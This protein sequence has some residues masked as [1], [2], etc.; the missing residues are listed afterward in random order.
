MINNT[1]VT[2]YYPNGL[3]NYLVL[4]VTT[5]KETAGSF[6]NPTATFNGSMTLEQSA[7][8]GITNPPGMYIFTKEVSVGDTGTI[9]VNSTQTATLSMAAF[10]IYNATGT[11]GSATASFTN[12][13]YDSTVAYGCE[14]FLIEQTTTLTNS[15]VVGCSHPP[16]I[17]NVFNELF[18][19]PD[20]SLT[21][22]RIDTAK[23]NPYPNL[24]FRRSEA[25]ETTTY[26]VGDINNPSS[27]Y[28]YALGNAYIEFESL[29]NKPIIVK[30]GRVQ[31]SLPNV[32][33]N[34][35]TNY[36]VI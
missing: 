36:E 17:Y 5:L 20:N 16:I 10:T 3:K 33:T 6:T 7:I 25:A 2:N 21:Y 30:N 27:P 31:A 23:D 35:I 32:T 11:Q 22:C 29:V 34:S 14:N 1:Q 4:A 15:V 18:N 13:T 9:T 8:S 24:F 28:T 19:L 26:K 12:I